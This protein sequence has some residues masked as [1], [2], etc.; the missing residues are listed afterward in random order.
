[1][2]KLLYV[3]KVRR[4]SYFH[5]KTFHS[6]KKLVTLTQAV[7]F[8]ILTKN[9][10]VGKF[11]LIPMALSLFKSRQFFSTDTDTHTV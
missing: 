1:M 9:R 7:R 11:Y 2:N 4:V 8:R 3:Q 10:I 6:H 5:H